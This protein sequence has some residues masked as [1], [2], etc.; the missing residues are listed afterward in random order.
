M[1]TDCANKTPRTGVITF[2]ASVI[3]TFTFIGYLASFEIAG[4][5]IDGSLE[6]IAE[7][8][9]NGEPALAL[10]ASGGLSALTGI[11]ENAG[12]ALDF[13]PDFAN[14]IYLYT[15]AVN[16]ASTYVKFT[17][18]ATA[19]TITILNGYDG[20]TTTVASG[21][22]SGPLAL[23]G[24]NTVTKFTI[25]ATETG[26]VSMVYVIYVTRAAA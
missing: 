22:Q 13:I 16:T 23:G 3:G 5:T 8:A 6:F 7:I 11:E 21:N 17:P 4:F 19:H 14:S 15:V 26:K 18:T 2:P 12:A 20:S 10:T 25:T 9:I 24:A 1:R